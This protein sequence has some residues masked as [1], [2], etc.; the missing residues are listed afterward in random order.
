MGTVVRVV[1]PAAV[2]VAVWFEKPG[3]AAIFA[4]TKVLSCLQLNASAY[5]THL[6]GE[7]V[8]VAILAALTAWNLLATA[9]SGAYA[10]VRLREEGQDRGVAWRVARWRR[11]GTD[12]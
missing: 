7:K 6:V 12:E 10:W 3:A 2:L 8:S 9:V 1:V 5:G 11:R 4:L